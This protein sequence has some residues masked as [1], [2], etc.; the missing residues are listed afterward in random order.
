[1]HPIKKLS[2][3]N[4]ERQL[5]SVAIAH[6][7]KLTIRISRYKNTN[8]VPMLKI[9]RRISEIFYVTIERYEIEMCIL[10]IHGDQVTLSLK[11]PKNTHISHIKPLQKNYRSSEK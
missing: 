1:M 5:T 8:G 11:M 10:D 4:P 9:I 2:A 6:I 7:K 3:G